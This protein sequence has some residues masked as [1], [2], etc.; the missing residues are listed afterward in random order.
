MVLPLRA[1]NFTV[2]LQ[3]RHKG[4]IINIGA[5]IDLAIACILMYP[6]YLLMGLP[7]VAFSFVISTYLQAGYYL[8]H[9]SRIL[10]VSWGKLLPVVN[11]TIKLIVFCLLFIV[12]HYLLAA[13]YTPQIVLICG[14]ILA[15]LISGVSFLLEVR[16]TKA[17]YGAVR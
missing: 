3:N 9:T 5:V 17:K 14:M 16:A 12:I 4:R 8:Y 15:A 13:Y 10:N 1:Y 7:G 11:W 2:V 6:L